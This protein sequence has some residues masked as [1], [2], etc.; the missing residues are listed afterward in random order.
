MMVVWG[1]RDESTAAKF[2]QHHVMQLNLEIR[3]P[4][5]DGKVTLASFLMLIIVLTLCNTKPVWKTN[6]EMWWQQS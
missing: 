6:D 1:E 4:H 3:N 2:F 5:H